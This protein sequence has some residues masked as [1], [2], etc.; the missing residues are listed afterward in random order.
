MN[1][2]LTQTQQTII[3]S[4]IAE[5]NMLN[6]PATSPNTDDLIAFINGQIDSQQKFLNEIRITNKLYDEANH[7]Q[8]DDI[9]NKLSVLLKNF[10]YG[11]ELHYAS[12]GI[13]CHDFVKYFEVKIYWHG[14]KFYDGNAAYTSLYF[15][16]NVQTKCN[17]SYLKDSTI[18]IHKTSCKSNMI[19][20]VDEL[21][22]HVANMIIE[23]KKSLIK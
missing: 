19:E 14:H 4:V 13:Q 10:G 8:V 16:S 7:S 6:A 3:D 9:V 12:K 20:S 5:F 22:K 1:T 17:I 11:V 18:Q 2:N 15:Y 23:K 21:M